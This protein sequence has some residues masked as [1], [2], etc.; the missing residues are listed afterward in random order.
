[1][2]YVGNNRLEEQGSPLRLHPNDDVNKSQSSNDTYPTS[3]HIASV[4]KLEGEVLPAVTQLKNTLLKKSADFEHIVK[5]DRTHLQDATPIT[6]GQEI[7]G[8]V[9]M[10]EKAE[11]MISE[12]TEYLKELAIGGTAVGTGLNAHPEFS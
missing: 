5:I 1:M 2:A 12:S 7:S 11:L 4:L 8:W 3:M 6:L 9:G 10:L